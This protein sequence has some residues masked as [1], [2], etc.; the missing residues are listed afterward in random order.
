MEDSSDFISVPNL[1]LS[2]ELDFSAPLQP[3]SSSASTS[4][5][6]FNENTLPANT[7]TSGPTPTRNWTNTAAN[8]VAPSSHHPSHSTPP[9][10]S[11]ADHSAEDTSSWT[12]WAKHSYSASSSSA[13]LSLQP[14]QRGELTSG[15]PTINPYTLG[16]REHTSMDNQTVTYP[17]PSN[18]QMPNQWLTHDPSNQAGETFG[19]ASNTGNSKKD[20]VAVDA[21]VEILPPLTPETFR[22]STTIQMATL[23]YSPSVYQ[24]PHDENLSGSVSADIRKRGRFDMPE[25][26]MIESERPAR[27]LCLNPIAM[28]EGYNS[29]GTSTALVLRGT[30][31]S[32]IEE[33]HV[34]ETCPFVSSDS[35]TNF[36]SLDFQSIIT[37]ILETYPQATN[38]SGPAPSVETPGRFLS[39]RATRTTATFPFPPS[40]SGTSTGSLPVV[41]KTPMNSQASRTKATTSLAFADHAVV[42]GGQDLSTSTHWVDGDI[43]NVRVA[44][45]VL[46]GHEAHSES[47]VQAVAS[48][49]GLRTRTHLSEEI[50]F[51]DTDKVTLRRLADEAVKKYLGAL[52]GDTIASLARGLLGR[53]S[54]RSAEVSGSVDNCESSSPPSRR[55]VYSIFDVVRALASSKRVNRGPPSLVPPMSPSK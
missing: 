41:E 5:H 36:S 24:P 33:E 30:V 7:L 14:S 2:I 18:S 21:N 38:T 25:S 11:A 4:N 9:S 48:S 15:I 10:I 49:G 54:K 16:Q 45:R 23:A 31:V 1:A 51:N 19:L 27:K 35:S 55:L 37:N 34:L 40:N 20:T 47:Q 53:G 26:V 43:E 12:D 29:K 52:D 32:D 50:R 42:P 22:A 3:S 39:P 6:L 8:E 28:D 13:T 46:M 44:K 17:V